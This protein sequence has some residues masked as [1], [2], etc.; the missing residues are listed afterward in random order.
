MAVGSGG[1]GGG[2]GV[3]VG[4][5][6]RGTAPPRHACEA[7]APSVAAL[8]RCRHCCKGGGGGGEGCGGGRSGWGC[9][10]AELG[11][12][13]DGAGVMVGAAKRGTARHACEA[14][15]PAVAAAGVVELLQ[16][17]RLAHDFWDWEQG[18]SFRWGMVRRGGGAGV[19]GQLG[20]KGG[21]GGEPCCAGTGRALGGT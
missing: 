7:L 4:A 9:N 12:R 5:A 11:R 20:G 8:R 6:K 17:G 21:W 1:S 15:A 13:R 14:L 18:A 16:S 3:M 2:A 10:R 19:R